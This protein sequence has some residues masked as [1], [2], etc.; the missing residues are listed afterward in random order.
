MADPSSGLGSS[1]ATL[2]ADVFRHYAADLHRYLRKRLHN[3]QQADDVV[4]EVFSRLVRVQH[5]ELVKKPHSYLFG[6]A[7]H[8]IREMRLQEEQEAV[9]YDS[10][11]VE[12]AAEHPSHVAR[13]ELSDQL[14]IQAQVERALAQLPDIHRALVLMCKRDGMTYAEAAVATGISVHMVEKHLVQARVKLL[15]MLWDL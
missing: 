13:D 8:V 4:Q 7:F 1:N 15:G 2:A 11:A 9:S 6:I 5:P 12:N 14:N 10:L 3:P